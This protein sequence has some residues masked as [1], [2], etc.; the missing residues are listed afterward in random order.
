MS[1]AFG[2]PK[3]VPQLVPIAR[4]YGPGIV[5]HGEVQNAIH[6]EHGGLDGAATDINVTR[7][8]A[9]SNQRRI[10]E[11][12]AVSSAARC[13]AWCDSRHPGQRE[14]HH[15]GL[16]DLR[17]RAI[18]LA[19]V[20]AIVGRPGVLERLQELGRSHSGALSHEHGRRYKE[21]RE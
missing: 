20:I 11:P 21:R 10:A 14:M 8:L 4:V 7:S 5:R 13:R 15:V 12:E 17:E 2:F 19:G 1:A 16:I 6:L 3:E 18:A 9:S